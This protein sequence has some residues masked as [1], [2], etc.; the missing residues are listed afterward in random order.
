MRLQLL[1]RKF[2][3]F[4]FLAHSSFL[5]PWKLWSSA[6]S[7]RPRRETRAWYGRANGKLNGWLYEHALWM[8]DRAA[9]EGAP[10]AVIV[11]EMRRFATEAVRF[12]I[13]SVQS[14]P[15][16]HPD[17]VA[18][19]VTQLGVPLRWRWIEIEMASVPDAP[20]WPTKYIAD[21]TPIERD[22]ALRDPYSDQPNTRGRMNFTDDQVRRAVELAAHGNQQLL[23]HAAGELPIE[24]HSQI[25][26]ASVE[27]AFARVPNR[28]AVF[29]PAL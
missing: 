13:T 12:G 25:A 24:T 17:R 11:A 15:A 9:T 29:V 1:K 19:L 8:K 18:P 16:V 23:F 10:D 26:M 20:H 14:M 4:F 7:A 21:G 27:D 3:W 6:K 5:S 22:A 28:H 2:N